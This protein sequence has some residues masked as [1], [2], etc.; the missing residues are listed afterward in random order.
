MSE[1]STKKGQWQAMLDAVADDAVER[2]PGDLASAWKAMVSVVR[3]DPRLREAV[4]EVLVTEA[5]HDR[6]RRRLQL[7]N[8]SRWH[9]TDFVDRAPGRGERL[10]TA[11]KSS[12]HFR[13]MDYTLIGGT[14]LGEARKAEVLK[15]AKFHGKQ[16]KR[17]LQTEVWLMMVAEHMKDKDRVRDVL[18]EDDLRL[19]QQA[20]IGQDEPEP[21]VAN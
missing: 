10:R 17:M 5:C 16:G 8:Q 7:K 9:Q 18:S 2:H 14:P 20:A 4:F 3:G 11:A 21:V 1:D 12:R 15:N 13:L 19:F 6:V